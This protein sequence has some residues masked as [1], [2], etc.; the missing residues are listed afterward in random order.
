MLDH[1]NDALADQAD[2]LA[3]EYV[4]AFGRSRMLQE[5]KKPFLAYLATKADQESDGKL[6]VAAAERAALSSQEYKRF[7]KGMV[8]A[9]RE[10]KRRYL[11][12]ENHKLKWMKS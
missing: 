11:M 9:E 3:N 7:F 8:E 4:E 2:R 5:S 1:Q 6:S 10:E 12:Y